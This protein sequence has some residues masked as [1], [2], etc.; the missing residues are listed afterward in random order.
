[1]LRLVSALVLAA[2]IAFS[3]SI[4]SGAMSDAVAGGGVCKKKTL[5]GKVKSWSCKSG[6]ICCSAPLLGYFGCGSKKF[7]CLF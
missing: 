5:S 7:G 2:A 3:G 6:Q 4:V 1:M